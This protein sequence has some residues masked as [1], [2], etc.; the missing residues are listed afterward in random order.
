MECIF[1]NFISIPNIISMFKSK[2]NPVLQKKQ[3]RWFQN[4]P[5]LESMRLDFWATVIGE[6]MRAISHTYISPNKIMGVLLFLVWNRIFTDVMINILAHLIWYSNLAASISFKTFRH[7]AS[8][9]NL[10]Q[11]VYV[12]RNICVNLNIKYEVISVKVTVIE[13]ISI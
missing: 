3:K 4:L 10:W 6:S 2:A 12:Y 9:I 8:V 11:T 13:Q 5:K 1:E 7:M